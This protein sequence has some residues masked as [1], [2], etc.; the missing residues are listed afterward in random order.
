MFVLLLEE[1]KMEGY[2]G[3]AYSW[4]CPLCDRKYQPNLDKSYV[5]ELVLNH[6]MIVHI[7]HMEKLKI[8][9]KRG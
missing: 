7:A 2:L 8:E 4:E 6:M 5:V 1:Q 9:V 3:Y